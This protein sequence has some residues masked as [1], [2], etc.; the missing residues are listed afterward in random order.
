M[1]TFTIREAERADLPAI[2][3]LL[4]ELAGFARMDHEITRAD[5]ER[6]FDRMEDAPGMYQNLVA[7][8]DGQVVGLLTMVYYQTLFHRGGTALINELVVTERHR[9]GGVGQALVQ[10][11]ME[12]AR[13]DGL[14]EIEVGTENDNA[15]ARAF[16]KRAGFDEEYVLLGRE[17]ESGG[18]VC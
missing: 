7:A 18:L 17:F 6:V 1:G 5:A 8:A 14:D 16:Y 9:G 10:R 12:M 3:G 11:A 2:V 13:R 15:R 4:A